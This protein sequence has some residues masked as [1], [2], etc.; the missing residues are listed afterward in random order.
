MT[1]ERW[2]S[3]DGSHGV[4]LGAVTGRSV[5]EE[6]LRDLLNRTVDSMR[7]VEAGA[8]TSRPALDGSS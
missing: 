5:D 4:G 3:F 2:V 1:M 7:R 8:P 6:G